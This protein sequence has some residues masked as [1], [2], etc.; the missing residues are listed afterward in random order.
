[1]LVVSD[2]H[3]DKGLFM[4]CVTESVMCSKKR[5]VLFMLF[6]RKMKLTKLQKQVLGGMLCG[7]V[8]MGIFN[9]GGQRLLM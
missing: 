1:M 7:A 2:R 6:T 3:G 9:P 5:S 8:C 4:W